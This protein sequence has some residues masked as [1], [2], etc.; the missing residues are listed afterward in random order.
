MCQPYIALRGK[1]VIHVGQQFVSQPSFLKSTHD[2]ILT[3]SSP[4]RQHQWG[5]REDMFAELGACTFY[6]MV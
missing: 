3:F 5:P 4:L 6:F 2:F 1:Q